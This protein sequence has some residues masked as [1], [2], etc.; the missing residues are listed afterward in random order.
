[1][2]T[3]LTGIDEILGSPPRPEGWLVVVGLLVLAGWIVLCGR[4]RRRRLDGA[5]QRL[6]VVVGLGELVARPGCSSWSRRPLLDGATGDLPRPGARPAR[7]RGAGR[8]AAA[9]RRAVHQRLGAGRAPRRASA[10][11]TRSWRTAG[12]AP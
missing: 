7:A 8:Q 12:C 10:A 4:Q 2:A 6:L 11:A 5:G 9:R 1:M 3:A